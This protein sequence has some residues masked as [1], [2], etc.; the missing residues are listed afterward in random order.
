[1]G[2]FDNLMLVSLT[3]S[4]ANLDLPN[5]IEVNSTTNIPSLISMNK[6]SYER[7]ELVSESDVERTSSTINFN[8]IDDYKISDEEII[9]NFAEKL[10]DG[11]KE[12]DPEF[13]KIV[14]ENFW[15]MV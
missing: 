4:S 7:Q 10:M 14:S 13:S 12:P 8:S 2:T 15:D 5:E 11:M 3:L 9:L 1:M 6:E